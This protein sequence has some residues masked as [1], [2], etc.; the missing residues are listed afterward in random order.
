MT[1][2]QKLYERMQNSKGIPAVEG[3]VNELLVALDNDKTN[4]NKLVELIT[5]DIALTQKVLKLVNSPMYISFSK[6]ISTVSDAIRILGLKAIVHIVLGAILVTKAEL[7]EDEELAKT[8][9][10]SELA[11]CVTEPSVYENAAIAAL[12][13]N[14][15]KL[16]ASK[17]LQEEMDTID[18]LVLKGKSTDEA[19]TE[20]LGMTLQVLGVEI[21][22]IWKLP[23]MITSILDNS[24]DPSLIN[25]ARFSNTAAS[26]IHEGR[27]SEVSDLIG[28]LKFSDSIKTRLSNLVMDRAQTV[29]VRPKHE[30]LKAR[31]SLSIPSME[32]PIKAKK[33][34]IEPPAMVT[35]SELAPKIILETLLEEIKHRKFE[36][37]FELA[38]TVFKRM[39]SSLNA[40]HCLY[41]KP[42]TE[43]TYTVVYGIGLDMN[44][45]QERFTV[46]LRADPN[47]IKTA[48]DMNVDI[49]IPD[50]DKLES[51]S[52]PYFFKELV[53][54]TKRFMVLPVSFRGAM[55]GML[56]FD[57]EDKD[58]THIDEIVIMKKIRDQFVPYSK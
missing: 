57:W 43:F 49:S 27:A 15:G 9:L 26:L 36:N 16:L 1:K 31:S 37:L 40:T 56:Y 30:A 5:S 55:R 23:R 20:V 11:K 46:N 47:V 50:V 52:F 51:K 25:L 3:T 21:A 48:V 17:Y 29:N 8:M 19:E 28:D 13:Y 12:L 42:M 45:V 24:G 54:N 39:V 7:E 33:I 2:I 22:K 4:T 14:V 58:S 10:A 44:K 34:A 18:A 35:P 41:L 32:I 53:P 38:E 6:D